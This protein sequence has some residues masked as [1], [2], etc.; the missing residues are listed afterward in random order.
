MTAAERDAVEGT[1]SDGLPA[2]CPD[3][4][5]ACLE[6]SCTQCQGRPT[7]ADLDWLAGTG[8]EVPGE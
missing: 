4:T 7:Q 5:D 8:Y 6:R 2:F 3:P 1:T